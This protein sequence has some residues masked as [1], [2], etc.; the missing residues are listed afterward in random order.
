MEG[1]AP[2]HGVARQASA[3]PGLRTAVVHDDRLAGPERAEEPVVV[4]DPD[5]GTVEG[6][7]K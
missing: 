7:R 6:V 5:Q 4:G 1:A 2:A 3:H